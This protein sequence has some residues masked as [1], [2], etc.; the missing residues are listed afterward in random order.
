MFVV[1]LYNR[2]TINGSG[3]NLE[4]EEV[5]FC[6]CCCFR[7]LF[8]T[9]CFL[10]MEDC[11]RSVGGGRGRGRGK[12]KGGSGG[13]IHWID[14]SR[15]K[16]TGP[17]VGSCAVESTDGDRSRQSLLETSQSCCCCCL[18]RRWGG[19]KGLEEKSKSLCLYFHPSLWT[20]LCKSSLV[21]Q[22]DCIRNCKCIN[23]Q[24]WGN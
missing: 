23:A 7:F 10:L 12:G 13:D 11:E 21:V 22:P 14:T 5:K 19:G 9:H 1:T 8:S 2:A 6:R 24:Q 20:S 15:L 17:T 4:I 16:L 18:R 3:L